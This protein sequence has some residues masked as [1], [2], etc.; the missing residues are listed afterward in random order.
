ME[1]HR[2]NLDTRIDPDTMM[3]PKTLVAAW[4]AA[5][6]VVAATELVASGRYRGFPTCGRRA[7]RDA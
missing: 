6:A 5:G 1:R 2:R 7:T 4:H 3:N